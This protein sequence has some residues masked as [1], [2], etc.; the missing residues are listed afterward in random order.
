MSDRSLFGEPDAA[1]EAFQQIP[2]AA[3]L[4]EGSELRIVARNA[5]LQSW[6]GPRPLLGLSVREAMPELEGQSWFEHCEEVVRTGRTITGEGFR[7]HIAQSDGS[8]LETFL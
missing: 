3:V 6:F 7:V 1:L 4:V 2:V 5:M 8:F